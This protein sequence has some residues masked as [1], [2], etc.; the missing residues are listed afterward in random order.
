MLYELAVS[1]GTGVA[2]VSG[3]FVNWAWESVKSTPITALGIVLLWPLVL[4]TITAL[5]MYTA[6]MSF[7]SVV[8]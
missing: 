1:W 4:L 7:R 3:M 5:M 8:R 2:I 6:V